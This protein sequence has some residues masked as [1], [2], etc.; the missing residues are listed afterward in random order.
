ML[1]GRTLQPVSSPVR[2]LLHLAKGIGAGFV[3]FLTLAF[4]EFFAKGGVSLDM[5]GEEYLRFALL[6][7]AVG[8]YGGLGADVIVRRFVALME[9]Y[10]ARA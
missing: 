2:A 1:V 9:R 10:Q 4:V 5:A 8:F 7:G 3:A 6:A